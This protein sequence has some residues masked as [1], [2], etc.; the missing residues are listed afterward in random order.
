M[1]F[2]LYYFDMLTAWLDLSWFITPKSKQTAV[3][4]TQVQIQ[5]SAQKSSLPAY[6]EY[7]PLLQLSS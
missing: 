7:E 6:T 2:F 3:I 4:H 5:V 1:K